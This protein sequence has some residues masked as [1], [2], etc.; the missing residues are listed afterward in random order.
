LSKEGKF[1]EVFKGSAGR[2]SKTR[3]VQIEEYERKSKN[4]K[5]RIIDTVGINDTKLS[6]KEVLNKIAE[7]VYHVRD[8]LNQILFVTNGKFNRG[9]V[10]IYNLLRKVIFDENITKYTTIVRTNFPEFDNEKE[11]SNDHDELLKENKELEEIFS[12]VKFIHVN[13]D[14]NS[15]KHFNNP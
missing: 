7:A 3:E 8:G 4:I 14:I 2:T 10:F 9:E 15:T 1:K 13:N 11:C 6:E 5:Y 12:S